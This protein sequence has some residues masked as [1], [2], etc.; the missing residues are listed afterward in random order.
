MER[1]KNAKIFK[2]VD[3]TNDDIF[4]GSTCIPMLSKR[5]A[6]YREC[7]K[8][9]LNG[10]YKYNTPF[11]IFKNND[12]DIVLIEEYPCKTKDQLTAR[13]RH[14]VEM[15]DCINK[16]IPGRTDKEYNEDNKE[17][18]REYGKQYRETNKEKIAARMKQYNQDNKDEIMARKKQYNKEQQMKNKESK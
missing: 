3:N 4:I 17:K 16:Y 5:L 2:I 1:Y 15:T 14:H 8:R 12:Y 9:Y 10:N 7:Y 11:K 13:L 18:R 6:R